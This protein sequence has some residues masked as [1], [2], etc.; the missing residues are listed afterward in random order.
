MSVLI[1]ILVFFAV[2]IVGGIT[3]EILRT[4][5]ILS[6]EAVQYYSGVWFLIAIV[7][8]ISSIRRHES[9]KNTEKELVERPA[10]KEDNREILHGSQKPEG[11]PEPSLQMNPQTVIQESIKN[12]QYSMDAID[13][14]SQSTLEKGKK[15]ILFEIYCRAILRYRGF[16]NLDATPVTGDHGGDIVAWKAKRKYVFQCK[17]FQKNV[18]VD[19]VRE[20]NIA[21]T[22]YAAGDAVVITNQHFTTSAKEEAEAT[23][24][25][26]W[27]R[28][29]LQKLI[30]L[31][32]ECAKNAKADP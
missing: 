31:A 5:F 11:T 29:E 4:S 2:I 18:G 22:M 26:L 19:A 7:L 24:V 17:C 10:K 20:A 1:G 9:K 8:S 12:Q 23:G 6:Q 28:S 15:G 21:R 32:N 13:I 25:L 30:D 3:G 27:D 14:L 16:S